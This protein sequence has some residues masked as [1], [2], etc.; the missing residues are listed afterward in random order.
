MENDQSDKRSSHLGTGLV[1]GIAIGVAS[2]LF[3]QSKKG[4]AL[5][6]DLGK[7]TAALQKKVVS[8]LKKAGD[9]T[10]ESYQDLVDKVVDYY[11][12]SK[13]IT[14]REVPEVKKTLLGAWKNIERELRN[15]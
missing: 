1:A 6:K 13:D 11:V 7:K 5:T 15:K 8:E 10:K 14:K 12:K 3:M 2:A 9:V 4:K